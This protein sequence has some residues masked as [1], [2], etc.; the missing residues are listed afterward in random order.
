MFALEFEKEVDWEQRRY[1]I[2]K[3]IIVRFVTH[4]DYEIRN[5]WYRMKAQYIQDAIEAADA[6]IAELQKG[7][8]K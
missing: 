2:V 6:I 1:E 7:G 8:E 4:N 3:D 5:E